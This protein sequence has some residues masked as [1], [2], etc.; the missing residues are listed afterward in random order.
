MIERLKSNSPNILGS[1]LGSKLHDEDYKQFVPAIDPA[2]ARSM[3]SE[4]II[5]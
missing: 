5:Q 3:L 2:L 4:R 1:K